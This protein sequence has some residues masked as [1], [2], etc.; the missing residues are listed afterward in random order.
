MAKLEIQSDTKSF[1]IIKNAIIDSEGILNEHEKILYMVLLRYGNKVFPSLVTLSKKCGFSKRTAQRTIDALI[2]KGLLKKR[3]R[4]NKKSGNTSNIYT[5][6]DNDKIW[7]STKENLKENI[8]VAI[9]E[10]AVRIVEAFG[11]KVFEKEKGLTS[12]PTKVTDASTKKNNNYV[13][14]Q[15]TTPVLKSQELL[16][17]GQERYTLDQ[18]KQLFDY[19]IMLHDNRHQRK[20]IDSVMDILHTTMNTTKETLRVNGE[21]K[22]SMIVIGKLMKLNKESI[23]YAINKFSEQTDRIKNTTAYMLTILYNTPEQFNLDLQN[24]MQY[25]MN[26]QIKD[27]NELEKQL[28]S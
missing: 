17:Q 19:D 1:T 9:L 12:E 14:E 26:T 6:I 18:I 25:N 28:L 3:N 2:E 13:Q 11:M 7:Y 4:I 24:Q 20:D 8:D 15:N 23:I 21:N 27:Y 16:G 5:L 10:E 22:P